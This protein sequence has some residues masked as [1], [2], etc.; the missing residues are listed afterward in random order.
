MKT[1]TQ[2]LGSFLKKLRLDAGLGLRKFAELLEMPASNLS[3]IEHNRRGIPAEKAFLAVEILGLQ[4]GTSSWEIFFDLASQS[5]KI[6][7]DIQSIASKG[8]VP[9]LLRTIDNY[10]LTDHD[11]Q[12][13]IQEIQGKDDRAQNKSR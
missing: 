6:P 2:N 12:N 8:F 1:K 3:A 9:A 7:A 5:E 13:L 11:I 4:K 10:Q